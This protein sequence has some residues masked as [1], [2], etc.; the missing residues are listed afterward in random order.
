MGE[1]VFDAALRAAIDDVAARLGATPDDVPTLGFS[2]DDGSAACWHAADG[3]HVGT[4]ERGAVLDDRH[5]TDRD[6][7]TSWV[8]ASIAERVAARHHSP[9]DDDYRR[10]A[11]RE[12][13]RLLAGLNHQWAETWLADTR[14]TLIESGATQSTL[15]KLPHSAS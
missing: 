8:A 10:A 12:Q 3:W 2:R 9:E 1:D 6:V 11:W 14:A 4:R 15:D 7:F 5:T 13:Y